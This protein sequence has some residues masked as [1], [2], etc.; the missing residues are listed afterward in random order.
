MPADWFRAILDWF[1]EPPDA[2]E[3]VTPVTRVA[4]AR[5]SGRFK[6]VPPAG[7]A[8]TTAPEELGTGRRLQAPGGSRKSSQ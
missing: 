6:P 7:P 5:P 4:G 8:L 2:G 1:E 3:Q